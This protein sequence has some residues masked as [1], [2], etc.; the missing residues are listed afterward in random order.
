MDYKYERSPR[1]AILVYPE[2]HRMQGVNKVDPQALKTGIFKYAY[3]R[4]MPSQILI[5]FG[6]EDVFD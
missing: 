4:K 2:G 6:N 1:P 5:T 3:R